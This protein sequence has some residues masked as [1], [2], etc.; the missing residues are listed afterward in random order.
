M[1]DKIKIG[2]QYKGLCL[3]LVK[4]D[5]PDNLNI[6]VL[7]LLNLG[8][9]VLTYWLFAYKNAILDAY[10]RTDITSKIMLVTST[11]QYFLQILILVFL[12]NYYV[13]LIVV[14]VTQIANNL[15]TAAIVQYKYPNYV[16]MGELEKDEVKQINCRIRDLFTSKLGG[17]IVNSA[18]TVVISAFLG[19]TKLAIYQNYYFIITSVIGVVG[20]VFS[21]CTAGIGN[22]M[23]TETIEKN[24]KDFKK[25][26]F[27]V[28]AIVNFC[29]SCFLCLFQPF[30]EVWVGNE[31]MLSFGMVVL[32]C[33][34]FIDYECMALLSVYK[35]ACGIWH[36]DR[37]RPLCEAGINLLLNLLLVNIGGLYGILLSTIISMSFVSLPWLVMNLFNFVFRRSSSEYISILIQN[38]IVVIVDM[39]VC[40]AICQMVHLGGIMTIIFRG[41]VCVVFSN[42][43]YFAIW[44]NNEDFKDA[45][46]L[47]NSI[48]K[49]KR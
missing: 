40:Y 35:D 37:F 14:L 48:F 31:L 32:F 1:T 11:I 25:F 34:Y 18:D 22:S 38:V 20:I 8:A 43:S 15:I 27:L 12:K 26:T 9:T 23:V 39:I 17:V 6:Y 28:M 46:K 24:Y 13:Y 42:I 30:M 49:G 4:S 2:L 16:A 19:L 41:A 36:H 3:Y 7:Y 5:L 21:S 29:T 10:Q 47:L 44:K 33:I 45:I